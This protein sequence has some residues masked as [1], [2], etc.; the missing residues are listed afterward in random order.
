[1]AAILSAQTP[2]RRV[3]DVT[4]VLFARYGTA[5]DYAS[6]DRAELEQ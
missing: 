6:V 1:V 4:R 5:A 2:D 3:N